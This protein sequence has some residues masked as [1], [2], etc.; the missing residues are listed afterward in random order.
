MPVFEY[1]AYNHSGKALKGILDADS[2]YGARQKLRGMGI[3]PVEVRETLS[4]AKDLRPGAISLLAFLKRVKPGE[5]SAMTRQLS[6]LLAA[7][8]PLVKSLETL[9]SQINNPMFKRIM[10]QIK[11]SVNE[12]NSLASSLSQHPRVF[13][14]FYINMVHSGEASGSL[15]VVLT[16]LAEFGERQQALRGRFK[17]ALAYPVF[18]SII[19]TFVLFFLI[20]FIV[21]NITS[22]FTEMHHTLPLPTILL[23]KVSGLLQSFWWLIGLALLSG[24]VVVRHSKKRPGFNYYWDKM[25]LRIPIIGPINQK[26]AIARFG[27]TLGS[28]LKSGVPLISAL[29]I[30]GKIVDNSLIEK[31]IDSAVEDIH[32]GKSLAS[33]L[34]QS[35][36]FPSMVIQMISVGEQSGELEVMLNKIAETHERE[37]ESNIIALTSILEPVMI[38]M[39]GLIVGFVVISIFL[40]IF[41]M[42]QIIK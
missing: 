4:K 18:M 5:I 36:W 16:H 29:Q 32:A 25:R 20:T 17:A 9:I 15:D 10:A 34:A 31:V 38:L 14:N 41:E 42:T 24:I 27:R 33:T 30:T 12:G 1:T 35:R 26:I 2:T 37:V 39:M 22:I 11:D 7:G 19:G 28:L 21:P 23:L 6:T 3:F 40:P 8:L 13:S